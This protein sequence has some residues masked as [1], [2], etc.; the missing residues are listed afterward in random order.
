MRPVLEFFARGYPAAW[1]LLSDL[2]QEV[3]DPSSA[4]R[5]S[6]CIRRYLES[7]PPSNQIGAAWQ[8]LVPLYRSMGDVMGGCAAFLK[9]AESL[10]PPLNEISSMANWLNQASDII[11]DMDIDDRRV[12]FTPLARLM[13]AR[14]VEAT[15]TDLSRLA[16]L[17]LHAGNDQRAL[18]VAELG[19][20]REPDNIHCGRLVIKLSHVD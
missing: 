6:E 9:A 5:A 14:L 10:T 15:A 13:E 17:H 12:L 19:L 1:L 7:H 3:L 2:E 16:W 11:A 4:H 18:E 20:E 8:R